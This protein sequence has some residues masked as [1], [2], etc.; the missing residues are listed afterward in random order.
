MAS[1][2]EGRKGCP[3]AASWLPGTVLRGYSPDLPRK[4]KKSPPKRAFRE[5]VRLQV[6]AKQVL[7]RPGLS[8]GGYRAGGRHVGI[9]GSLNVAANFPGGGRAVVH[10][11]IDRDGDLVRKVAAAHD[12]RSK[13]E[14]ALLHTD[15]A[16]HRVGRLYAHAVTDHGT[17][18]EAGQAEVPPEQIAFLG[19]DWHCRHDS[20]VLAGCPG[21]DAQNA[22]SIACHG[23]LRGP[24]SCRGGI[25]S[26]HRPV[27]VLV[28]IDRGGHPVEV[29]DDVLD[30]GL[31]DHFLAFEYAAEQKADDDE[32]DGDFHQSE[33]GLGQALVVSFHNNP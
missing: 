10:L 15:D 1:G 29:V 28:G 14:A 26:G 19:G 3:R 6:L 32:H 33:T 22:V 31:G 2:T 27:A 9:R 13:A 30:L 17:R 12:V 18:Y 8:I 24:S 23:T 4:E 5:R 20:V 7:V 25:V 21:A 16:V 11:R